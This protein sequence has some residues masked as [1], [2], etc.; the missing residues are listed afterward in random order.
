MKEE[1]TKKGVL[2]WG[3]AVFGALIL[4]I[5]AFRQIYMEKAGAPESI[6][7]ARTSD[8]PSGTPGS[9]LGID[10]MLRPET[11]KKAFIEDSPGI[12]VKII[13]GSATVSDT[14]RADVRLQKEGITLKYQWMKDGVEIPK[15][16]EV[17]LPG[18]LL[19]K[20][21]WIA[22]KVTPYRGDSALTSVRSSPVWVFNSPPQIT[23]GKKTLEVR[24]DSP[25]ILLQVKAIDADNDPITFTLDTSIKDM[26]IN[27]MT[28]IITWQPTQ[29][30]SGRYQVKVTAADNDGGKSSQILTIEIP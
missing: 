22:V 6:S 9:V 18:S 16:N 28:G 14:L 7:V 11:A 12:D 20:K 1:K 8:S 29:K 19:K 13:P 26:T 23:E 3:A 10:K 15:A 17:S 5:L 25:L 4:L 27:P 30:K 24:Q 21:C 2:L